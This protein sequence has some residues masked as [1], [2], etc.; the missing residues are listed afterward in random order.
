[1]PFHR[2][3][4]PKKTGQAH[5]DTDQMPPIPYHSD[6]GCPVKDAGGDY[7]G[8]PPAVD[9]SVKQPDSGVPFKVK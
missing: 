7:A 1:M 5:P 6:G 3:D 2:S 9:G 8:K 4:R